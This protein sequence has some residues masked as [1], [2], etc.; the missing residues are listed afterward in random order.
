[1]TLNRQRL[2]HS[3]IVDDTVIGLTVRVPTEVD[4]ARRTTELI[5]GNS[6]TLADITGPNWT[7]KRR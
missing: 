4:L 2:R 6:P 7:N 1:V 3:P 5:E